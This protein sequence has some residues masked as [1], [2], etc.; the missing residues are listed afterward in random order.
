MQLHVKV[1]FNCLEGVFLQ[2]IL[3]I[4]Y[5]YIGVL[6]RHNVSQHTHHCDF[7]VVKFIFIPPIPKSIK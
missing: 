5:D 3:V 1:H 6:T 4:F 7:S 2:N